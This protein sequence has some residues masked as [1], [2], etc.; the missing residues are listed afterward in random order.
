MLM[1]IGEIS[2]SQAALKNIGT[3]VLSEAAFCPFQI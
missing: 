2:E 3:A 1:L